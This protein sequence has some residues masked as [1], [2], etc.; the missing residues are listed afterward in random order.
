VAALNE[1][2][3]VLAVMKKYDAALASVERALTYHPQYA[4]AYLN[5]GNVYAAQRNHGDA[6]AAYDRAVALDPNLADAWVGRGNV[7]RDSRQYADALSAYGR[8]LQLRPHLIE[9]WLGRGNVLCET[10]CGEDAL[11]AYDTVLE[12]SPRLSEAWLGRG[13]ILR[14][15]KR[16]D[17]ALAAYDTALAHNPN[18]AEAWIGRG[19]IL[20]EFN[21]VEDAVAEFKRAHAVKPDCAEARIASCFGTL[22]TLYT[23]VEE[24]LQRRTAYEEEL[25]ALCNDVES[26]S[27]QGDLVNAIGF[28]LPFYLAY[29]G[30]NDVKL[31]I[32]YGSL[33]TYVIG[34]RF[35]PVSLPA[36][37]TPDELVRVG[38]VSN[39]FCRH[40]NWKIPVKGWISQ[41][42]RRRFKIFGYHT[43]ITRDAE[44]DV[45]AAMCDRFVHRPLTLSGWRQEILADAPH[46]LIY[47]GL[48]M[49]SISIGLAAQRLAPVQCNSWGHPET[50]GLP[51][52]DY[53]LSSDLMEPPDAEQHYSERLIRLPNLSVYCEPVDVQAVATSK[54]ELGFRSSATVFWCGQSLFKYLPQFDQVF[55]KIA[56]QAP[57]CQFVFLRHENPSVT[58]QFQGRLERAFA[59]SG[60][61]SSDYCVL[62]PRLSFDQFVAAMGQCD[63][64]LDSIGWSGCNSTLESL[65]HNL[66]IVTVSGSLM[67]GR[68]SSAILQMMGITETIAASVEEYIGIA[69]RLANH[70]DERKALSHKI[71]DT[72]HR[73]YHDRSC[74][75][76]LEEFLDRAARHT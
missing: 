37:P 72:K 42:D 40:S 54:A 19:N 46:V 18:L 69:A 62:L 60:L 67:R 68:H 44:T 50:S 16:W 53:Y 29:Q 27:V 34:K 64:F 56:E 75:S 47:P 63:V 6:L 24:I 23:D 38:I 22:P 39:F 33:V 55:P 49:D 32:R 14:E 7:F 73:V 76:A 8:A 12:L 36:P 41:M 13:N 2:A 3:S 58:D 11:A 61:H 31:Q 59:L 71:A 51:T 45:A 66:P 74:I 65:P 30:L 25:R 28:K 35:P 20:F 52:L 26:G 43:G 57:H 21:R 5:K 10:K 48:L 9:A 70:P 4:E 17:E 1:R 15:L